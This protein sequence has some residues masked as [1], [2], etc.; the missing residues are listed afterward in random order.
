MAENILEYIDALIEQ[1]YREED[2][3]KM[4]NV[5]FSDDFSEDDGGNEYDE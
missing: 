1:G 2:A 3:E 5:M 4:A